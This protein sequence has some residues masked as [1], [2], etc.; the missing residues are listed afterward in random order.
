MALS[1]SKKVYCVNKI[2]PWMLVLSVLIMP[3]TNVLTF[4]FGL[5]TVKELRNTVVTG[6]MIAYFVISIIVIIV[7]LFKSEKMKFSSFA[8]LSIPIL[9]MLAAYTYAI[10]RY[11]VHGYAAKYLL[12]FGCI[13]VP[14]FYIGYI[15]A[16]QH[17]Q[18]VFVKA[19][20]I[21]GWFLLPFI[22]ISFVWLFSPWNVNKQLEGIGVFAYTSIGYIL[23]S[24]MIIQ[25]IMISFSNVKWKAFRIV[26]LAVCAFLTI[27]T[28]AKGPFVLMVIFLSICFAVR[29]FMQRNEKFKQNIGKLSHSIIAAIVCFSTIVI[30][31]FVA[32]PSN[33]ENGRY[34]IASY[35]IAFRDGKI[36]EGYSF[37]GEKEYF[38]SS[39]NEE[40]TEK[41][42]T[43]KEST[44]KELTEKESAGKEL[45][46]KELTEKE[47]TEKEL[48]EKE[49]TEKELT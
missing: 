11:G 3:I 34:R 40:L 43:E 24:L 21:Y 46:E 10:I 7:L 5:H 32:A 38:Y 4:Y 26:E 45:T 8:L 36:Q 20:D 33:I 15:C 42:L 6:I 27:A 17:K 14:A 9:L 39:G 16:R 41:E 2:L 18:Q 29:L 25:F 22:V 49:L 30:L 31:L 28:G 48:T 35:S 13:C 19:L 44:E 1:S 12:Q 47:L 37:G 23:V